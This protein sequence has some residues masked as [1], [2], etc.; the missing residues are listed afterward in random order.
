MLVGRRDFL[1]LLGVA[2]AA[3]ALAPSSHLAPA[4]DAYANPRLGLRFVKPPGWYFLSTVDFVAAKQHQV[5]DD[6]P[7]AVL[8][9][10]DDPERLPIVVVSKFPG[11]YPDLNPYFAVWD[12]PVEPFDAGDDRE[13]HAAGLTGWRTFMPNFEVLC[14]PAR[15]SF[16]GVPATRSEWRFRCLHEDGRAWPVA[17]TTLLVFRGDRTHTTN[18]LR[19]TIESSAVDEDVAAALLSFRYA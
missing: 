6:P 17:V 12:E 10:L 13:Y 19:G 11:E 9:D 8:A 18:V 1:R 5:L 16:A 3:A 14:P 7:P 15:V 4:G 2:A